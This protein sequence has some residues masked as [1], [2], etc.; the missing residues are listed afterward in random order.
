[1]I[2]LGIDGGGSKTAF[3]LEDDSGQDISH[4][5]TGPSNRLSAG[6]DPARQSIAGGIARLPVKPDAVCGGFA[7]AGRPEGRRFYQECLET[8]LPH[9]RIIVESDA[10]VAYIGAIGIEPGVLLVAGT[11]S[12][13][14]GRR[15]DAAMIRVGGWGPFFGD[16]G[17]GYW[18]G[19]E[20][21]R[22]ALQLHDVRANAEFVSSVSRAL[23]LESISDV[24][25]AWSSGAV[26]IYSIASLAPL[27]FKQYPADPEGRILQEAAKHLRTITETA[28]QRVGFPDCRKSVVGSVGTHPVMRQLLG[29]DCA[30]PLQSP[31]RG[32]II[33]ARSLSG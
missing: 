29:I 19:R 32:A 27:I 10:F 23:G 2:V 30:P 24:V 13:A 9:T 14:I 12:I 22:T 25:A 6:A 5:E 11:G 33:W 21:V 31:E 16:E 26:S 4:F 28:I 1:M 15:E 17:S 18:I 3:L 8:L 7:G 20:A